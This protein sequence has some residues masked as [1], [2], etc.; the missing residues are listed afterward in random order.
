VAFSLES[1]F[2]RPNQMSPLVKRL[3]L[4]VAEGVAWTL[5]GLDAAR[6]DADRTTLGAML[7]TFVLKELRRQAAWRPDPIDFLHFRDRDDVEV[8]VVLDAEG[9]VAGV[10]AKAA[11]T[12]D[13]S[14]LRGLPKPRSAAGGRFGA[15]VI[16]Y[17]GS[18]MITFGAAL[19]TVPVRKLC[20]TS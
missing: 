12:V 6:L 9:V 15:S 1:A 14:D 7:G 17:D 20:E 8:D 4:H 3:Q 16:L 18:A 2:G 11:A 19:F 13:E 10:V 5:R